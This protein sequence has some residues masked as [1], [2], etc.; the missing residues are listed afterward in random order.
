MY[1]YSGLIVSATRQIG[2]IV[3]GHQCRSKQRRVVLRVR[4]V[5]QRL[6]QRQLSQHNLS[7]KGGGRGIG[8]YSIRLPT[9]R[10]L[11]GKVMVTLAP[12]IGTHPE[13]S[14]PK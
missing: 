3:A 2:P 13:L 12:E 14:F 11:G 1:Q 4:V 9:E 7:T 6:I 8:T 5:E 10:Y